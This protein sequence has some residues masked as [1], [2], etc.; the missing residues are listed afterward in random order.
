MVVPAALERRWSG[1]G[2]ALERRWSGAAATN[3]VEVHALEHFSNESNNSRW[4]CWTC[5]SAVSKFSW[6]RSTH[7]CVYTHIYVTRQQRCQHGCTDPT[8]VVER[9]TEAEETAGVGAAGRLTRERAVYSPPLEFLMGSTLWN[10]LHSLGM[11]FY[12]ICSSVG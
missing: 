5:V 6:S 1:A 11:V 7:M 4:F 10:F 8:A 2:A 3:T 12:L 9:N